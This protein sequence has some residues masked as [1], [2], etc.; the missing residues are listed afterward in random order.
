MKTFQEW[1]EKNTEIFEMAIFR[2]E[3][4]EGSV[5]TIAQKKIEVKGPG[6]YNV[7]KA[8]GDDGLSIQ[9]LATALIDKSK[10]RKAGTSEDYV[11]VEA[12]AKAVGEP[13]EKLKAYMVEQQKD[14]L[15]KQKAKS[16]KDRLAIAG[17]KWVLTDKAEE[18]MKTGGGKKKED[19]TPGFLASK[20]EAEEEVAEEP[21]E[22]K[23]PA[24][25]A[26]KAAEKAE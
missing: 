13:V 25:R 22:E 23:K 16:W 1:A 21:K 17:G 26:R 7:L 3:G 14:Q 11:G 6:V 18:P 2:T 4:D 19:Y 15:R 8:A 10:I 20:E 24:R 9:D 12:F 5:W